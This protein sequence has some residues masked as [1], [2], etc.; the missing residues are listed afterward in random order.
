M[1][2]KME[3]EVT[4]AT[5]KMKTQVEGAGHSIVIDEPQNMG[6]ND[7][8][9]DPLTNM[10]ASLAGCENV[11]AN[12]VAKEMDFDL[13]SIHFFIKGE[14]DSRGLMGEPGVRPF[15]QRVDVHAQLVTTETDD[16]I[17]EMQEKVDAR[18]PVFTTMK[19]A[20]TDMHANWERG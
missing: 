9:P 1:V 3:F 17:R 13:Q 12:M 8:G 18:C 14:L 10:L 2:S 19:A 7:E 11:V 6:G 16:R 15:F 4:G 20:G 5:D